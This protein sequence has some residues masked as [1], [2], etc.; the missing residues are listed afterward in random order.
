[1]ENIS[2]GTEENFKII[3]ASNK[4]TIASFS[5]KWCGPCRMQLPILEKFASENKDVQIIKLNV[6]ENLEI[7]KEYEVRNIPTLIIFKEG[8]MLE[9]IVGLQQKDQL[10]QIKER[11]I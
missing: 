9:K 1:M 6:D 8:E 7:S 2:E 10:K 5:A 11:L 3:V 4:L